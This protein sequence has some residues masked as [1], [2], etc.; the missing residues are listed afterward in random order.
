MINKLHKF[1]ALA[2]GRKIIDGQQLKAL[3]YLIQDIK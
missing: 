3:I 2:Y 1:L